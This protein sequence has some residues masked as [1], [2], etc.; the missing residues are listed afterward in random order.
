MKRHLY[1]VCFV[2]GA[3]AIVCLTVF[4]FS[5][6]ASQKSNAKSKNELEEYKAIGALGLRKGELKVVEEQ[7]NIQ[8]DIIQKLSDDSYSYFYDTK[9]DAVI[10]ISANDQAMD[11]II[12]NAPED[13]MV[14]LSETKID[15]KKYVNK[16]FPEYDLE[17]IKVE[18][19]MSSGS[20]VESYRY[21]ISDY[22]DNV[23]INNAQ[24]S[25]SYDGQ[26]TFVYGTHNI[27]GDFVTYNTISEQKAISIAFSHLF[28]LKKEIEDE[29]NKNYT[30]ENNS[31]EIIATEDMM[32]PDGI[33]PGD[34]FVQ[35]KLPWYQIYLNNIS[36]MNVLKC[37]KIIYEN[38]VVWL[39]E[40]TVKTSWG[41][42]DTIFNPLMHVYVDA[43]SGN[44][45]E[46]NSTD[47]Y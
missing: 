3:L 33:N 29:A 15:I 25:F 46:M 43:Q 9:K 8:G 27:I 23:Q 36:D 32:L 47:G 6:F 44:V 30:T 40:F 31:K 14:G 26:L 24:M 42:I 18:L 21:K 10:V 1:R 45:L 37:E 22:Q 19:D 28:S 4:I 11:K 41:D 5:G 34:S 2:A 7:P 16:F 17:N 12:K 38:T 35:E 20:P 13:F 39:V